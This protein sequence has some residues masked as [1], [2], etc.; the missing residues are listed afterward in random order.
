M[1]PFFHGPLLFLRVLIAMERCLDLLLGAIALTVLAPILVPVAIILRFTGEGEVFYTQSRIGWL[2]T[3]FE[4]VKFA[5]MLRDSPNMGSLDLTLRNDQRVLPFGRFLRITK[6]N[7]LPQILNVISGDMSFVGPR[8]HT[9]RNFELFSESIQRTVTT[10]RP[11]VTGI[12]SIVF[13]DEEG[14]LEGAADK[15][16]FYRQTIMP[17]KGE[18]E[19]WYVNNRNL[20]TYFI[21]IALTAWVIFRPKS[22]ILWKVFPDLP[23]PPCQ[24]RFLCE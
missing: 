8:P 7:E 13:R 19:S 16:Q 23:R 21:I 24:L 18:L 10:I 12:G 5:T 20:Y 1:P 17:Y 14:I 9:Q 6:I 15:M 11:G 3:R 2:G 22:R 4:M